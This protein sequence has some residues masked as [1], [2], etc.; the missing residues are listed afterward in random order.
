MRK[1]CVLRSTGLENYNREPGMELTIIVLFRVILQNFEIK[2]NCRTIFLET[3][4]E[5][6]LPSTVFKDTTKKIGH[7]PLEDNL[8]TKIMQ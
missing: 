1:L 2:V 3:F 5:C 7:A 4:P 8:C 6:F